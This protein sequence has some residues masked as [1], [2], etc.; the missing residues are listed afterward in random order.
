MM[1]GNRVLVP[2][3]FSEHSARAL[4][5]AKT[6]AEKFVA[7]LHVLTVV[8]DPFV[9]PDPGPWYVCHSPRG[10]ERACDKTPSRMCE[11]CS[12][13]RNTPSSALKWPLPLATRIAR[14]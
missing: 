10:T 12:R 6:L 13:R 9:L 5:C 2:V 8:P 7:S 11:D 14:F 1:T 3:D 4:D